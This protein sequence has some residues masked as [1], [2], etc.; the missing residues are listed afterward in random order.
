[1]N[2]DAQLRRR[3]LQCG[4]SVLLGAPLVVWAPRA[5]AAKREPYKEEDVYDAAKDFFKTGAKELSDVLAKVLRE[6]GRPIAL[7]PGT[8]AGGAIGVGLR[9]GNGELKY[10]NGAGR[11]V[12]WQGPSLGFDIGANVV[13][14]FALVYN[15]PNTEAIFQRFP[16][17]EGSLYFVGGFGVN[18]VQ[19]NDITI[20]P[21]RFGIGWRQG[22]GVGYMN[23]SRRK[24]IN[25]F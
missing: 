12:Y 13:K 21:V 20:A 18:Y 17:V 2:T 11:R 22:I 6:K 5:A 25:P 16:G 23:F 14:V 19:A 3:L 8:E 9:Y 10:S 4:G 1:M 24:R 7:I 15:L